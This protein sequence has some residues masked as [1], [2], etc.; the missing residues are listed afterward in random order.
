M[1]L[2]LDLFPAVAFQLCASGG[3]R[4]D[5]ASMM[6]FEEFWGS[7]ETRSLPRI[8]IQYGALHFHPPCALA[9]HVARGGAWGMK[10]RVDV[11]M[12]GRLG[13]ELNPADFPAKDLEE[14]RRGIA[15]YKQ[16]RPVLHAAEV[17]RGRNPHVSKT[18]EL[19]Y[20]LPDRSQAVLL[21]FDTEAKAH[22]DRIHPSG[23]DPR[24]TYEW[25][26]MN[27]DGTPRLAPGRATGKALLA[28]GIRI[29]FPAGPSTAVALLR[30]L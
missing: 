16:L 26:E 11:A 13:V 18:S 6:H 29:A 12:A 8:P 7:D 2:F 22:A 3:G 27:P 23:L 14:I 28:R 10:M 9:S 21:A 25:V 17:F 30:A 5:A 20:V 15:A 1:Q 4:A 24:R 19:T